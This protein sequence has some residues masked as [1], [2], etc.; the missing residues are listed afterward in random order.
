[1]IQLPYT[2]AQVR[3]A[4]TALVGAVVALL[5]HYDIVVGDSAGDAIL[6]LD[7]ILLPLFVYKMPNEP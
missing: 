5:A 2:K 3:K 4:I 6:V 7:L 1:M